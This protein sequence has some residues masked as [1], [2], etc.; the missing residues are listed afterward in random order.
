MLPSRNKEEFKTLCSKENTR[1]EGFLF[2]KECSLEKRDKI[3]KLFQAMG[4]DEIYPDDRK[5]V[6]KAVQNLIRPNNK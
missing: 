3:P 1:I 2:A 6:A 5:M 4:V